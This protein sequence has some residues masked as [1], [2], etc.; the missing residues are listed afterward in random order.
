MGKKINDL[1]AGLE[2]T[3]T[4]DVCGPS[5]E[6]TIRFP[7]PALPPA[8]SGPDEPFFNVCFKQLPLTALAK[9]ALSK[10]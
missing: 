9:A 4:A 10:P 5:Y 8:P 7:D 1:V 3:V 2:D 6:L